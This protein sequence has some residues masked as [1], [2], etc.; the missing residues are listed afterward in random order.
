MLLQN[1]KKIEGFLTKLPLVHAFKTSFGK[2][3]E[4]KILIV[5]ATKGEY[6]GWGEITAG[7]LPL[8]NEETISS[9]IL[10]L[11]EFLFPL[12]LKCGLKPK[13]FEEQAERF[14]GNRMAK[15]GI[16]LA[17]WDLK[18]KIE[19]KP[20]WKLYGGQRKEIPVG[21]SIGIQRTV[22]E[23]V[24]RISHFWGEGYLRIKIKIAPEWDREVIRI[25]R[26]NFPHLPLGVDANSAYNKDDF[27]LLKSLDE[28]KL[29]FLEQPLYNNDL[30]FH[31][32]LRKKI[33]NPV[34]LDE[35]ITS[36]RKLEE[37]YFMGSLSIANI[38]VGRIGGVREV[39]KA[40]KFGNDKSLPF[41]CGGMLES[42]V[43]RAHNLHLASLP[44]FVLPADLSETKRYFHDDVTPEF[45]FSSPGYISVPQGDGIGVEVFEGKVRE[46]VILSF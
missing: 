10:A 30:Y 37:A 16:S 43:G 31:S 32:L 24:E 23:L 9:A 2:E 41:F 27:E 45:T 12:A 25:I 21:V 19:G 13:C 1:E 33:N 36:A 42:G 5:K 22:D 39:L 35:S 8:Y 7:E 11:K 44:P 20:L 26:E 38:K 15:A 40:S 14:K 6:S 29:L 34:A 17:L 28:F 3:S 18:G 4:R 46:K